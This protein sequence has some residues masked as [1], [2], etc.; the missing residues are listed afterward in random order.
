MEIVFIINILKSFTQGSVDIDESSLFLSSMG[1]GSP[2]GGK[3]KQNW[4]G[5]QAT[6]RL[7]TPPDIFPI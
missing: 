6:A 2:V 7:A 3:G 4:Q 5:H 1:P